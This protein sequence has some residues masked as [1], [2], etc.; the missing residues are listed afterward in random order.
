MSGLRLERVRR[1]LDCARA[2]TDAGSELRKQALL[3]LPRVTGLS[4][5]NVVWALDH[6]LEINAADD[7]LARLCASTPV[8]PRAHVL[9]S[10]NVFV[11][12]LRAIAIGLACAPSVFVKP[13]RREPEMVRLLAQAAPGQ[14]EVVEA[15]DPTAGDHVWAYGSDET[16][17]Q[18]PRAWPEGV[19]LH[20]HGSGFGVVAL[21]ASD[22]GTIGTI[23]ELARELAVDVAAFDQRG[24]LSPRVVVVHENTRGTELLWRAL[25]LAM[26]ERERAIPL[27]TL[28]TQERAQVRRFRDTLCMVGRVLPAGS[29]LVSLETQPLPSWILPPIG[30]VLHVRTATDAIAELRAQSSAITTIGVSGSNGGWAARLHQELPTARI[31]AV[32]SLQCP[33]LDGPVDLRALASLT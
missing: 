17:A 12:A 4:E 32:G 7:D 11:A 16:M 31:A 24:C 21:D 5:Q 9:L 8:A 2:L 14:F 22:L 20:A 26:A 28:T 10:A 3:S 13:S 33:A 6:A 15:L 27:G 1:L 23:D 18:L 25:A 19:T 29:G 30:R